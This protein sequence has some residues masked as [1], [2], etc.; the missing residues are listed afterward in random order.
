MKNT[1]A[2][3]S[4]FTLVTIIFFFA[5][6]SK[7]GKLPPSDVPVTT[8]TG[9]TTGPAPTIDCDTI[10][11][12]AHIAPIIYSECSNACHKQGGTGSGPLTN[13]AEVYSKVQA[14]S[15]RQRVLVDKSMPF[16]SAG[17]NSK[18]LQIIQ[19]WLDKGAPNN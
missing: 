2:S 10:K 1:F 6:D 4:F 11:Y 13:Y 19:C 15:F 3:I 9:S 18:Q 8:T 12:S 5:C 16:G 17:L 14:G 7:V